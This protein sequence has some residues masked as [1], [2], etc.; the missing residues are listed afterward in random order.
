MNPRTIHTALA[1]LL[2]VVLCAAF[3]APRLIGQCDGS[4]QFHDSE[5]DFTGNCAWIEQF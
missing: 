3:T 4:L 2:A 1:A 5:S